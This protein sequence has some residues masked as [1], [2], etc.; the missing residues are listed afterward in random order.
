MPHLTP[1]MYQNRSKRL[2]TANLAFLGSGSQ[3][4]LVEGEEDITPPLSSSKPTGNYPQYKKP[5]FFQNA[6]T[7]GRLGSQVAQ[8]NQASALAEARAQ[9]QL[10]E[11]QLKAFNDKDLAV[12]KQHLDLMQSL[13][14]PYTAENILNV[15][16]QM[17]QVGGQ[18]LSPE[19][20]AQLSVKAN[21]EKQAIT[22]DLNKANIGKVAS[23]SIE[24]KTRADKMLQE[25]S[26]ENIAIEQGGKKATTRKTLAEAEKQEKANTLG[27]TELGP[28]VAVPNTSPLFGDYQAIQFNPSTPGGI[29]GIDEKGNPKFSGPMAGNMVVT[30]FGK[31]T[32]PLAPP[33]TTTEPANE[34]IRITKDGKRAV[35]D[36]T[37]KQFIRYAE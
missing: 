14:M 12:L 26:P 3:P 9:S 33:A 20:L 36:A 29:T 23:E 24:A 6:L 37:T 25:M 8:M 21:A 22:N 4:E 34:V 2:P 16:N 30:P 35:F 5:G 18:S 13:G 11:T 1:P 17:N 7:G 28:H 10:Q 19:T 32:T 15:N 31:T 27:I